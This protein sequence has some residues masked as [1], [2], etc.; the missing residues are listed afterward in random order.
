[1]ILSFSHSVSQIQR[2]LAELLTLYKLKEWELMGTM[3]LFEE[4]SKGAGMEGLGGSFGSRI[5]KN[6]TRNM[7]V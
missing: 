7:Y 5:L 3:D 6:F 4:G 2:P 1:M